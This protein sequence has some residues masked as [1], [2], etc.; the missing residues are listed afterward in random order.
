MRLL[1]TIEESFSMHRLQKESITASS[2]LAWAAAA[3]AF[4]AS[5][6]ELLG[7]VAFWWFEQAATLES[8][9]E[10]QRQVMP[11]LLSG[12]FSLSTFTLAILF[13]LDMVPATLISLAYCC[14]G[15]HFWMLANGNAWTARNIR[16]I[17]LGGILCFCTPLAQFIVNLLQSLALSIEVSKTGH[18]VGFLVDI[19]SITFSQLVLGLLLCAFSRLM[20]KTQALSEENARYI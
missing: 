17:W 2:Y 10:T 1:L 8:I 15:A 5:T 16:L 12:P 3:L 14:A 9:L 18:E 19:S 13:L 7:P 4:I 6:F 11:G 20:R